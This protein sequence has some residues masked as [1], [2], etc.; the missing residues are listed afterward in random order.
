MVSSEWS[1]DMKRQKG[2]LFATILLTVVI[3]LPRASYSDGPLDFV[4][5]PSPQEFSN[6]C[7][8]YSMA[9]SVTFTPGSPFVA[10]TA[11]ELRDLERRT[12]AA[13]LKS[14]GGAEPIRKDWKA[15]VEAVTNGVLTVNWKE[16]S[17][18]DPAM[19]FA[20]EMTGI[21]NPDT[22]GNVLSVSLVK[23]P[24]ML[25]FMRIGGS[26]YPSGHI[27]TVFGVQLPPASMSNSAHPKLLLVNSAVK[28]PGGIKNIC[29]EEDLSDAD[30]YRAIITLTDDYDIKPMG[31]NPYLITYTAAK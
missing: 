28:Y 24:V 23:T 9:M 26:S 8:S 18:L 29:A 30:K 5:N 10:N 1:S 17:D 15:A 19:R 16:F 20:A 2:V 11:M 14:A 4:I 27:V 31:A 22:L 21:S 7:Q 13:L 6:T 25:S 3:V 12:R